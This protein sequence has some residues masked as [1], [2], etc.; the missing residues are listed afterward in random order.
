[1]ALC[2]GVALVIEGLSMVVTK[3]MMEAQRLWVG[4]ETECHFRRRDNQAISNQIEQ[5]EPS[6]SDRP[7]QLCVLRALGNTLNPQ[8]R[9]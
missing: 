5:R 9:A 6:T 8:N 7:A 1:M 2:Y 3:P 4:I